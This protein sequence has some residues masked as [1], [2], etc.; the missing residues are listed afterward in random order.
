MCM[1]FGTLIAGAAIAA[2]ALEATATAVCLGA[3]SVFL[4]NR[5]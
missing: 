1:I 4:L 3:V 2:I 5:A